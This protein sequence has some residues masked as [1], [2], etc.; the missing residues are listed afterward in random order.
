MIKSKKIILPFLFLAWTIIFAHSIIP[1]H[2]HHELSVV[3]KNHCH[4]ESHKEHHSHNSQGVLSD[5][6]EYN[7]CDH[8]TSEQACHFN[9]K[10]LTQVS[11]DNVFICAEENSL[12]SNLTCVKTNHYNFY[13]DFISEEFPKTNYLR[14]P[15]SL[16]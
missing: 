3:E 11:I 10:V 16:A 5:V 13:Q 14:G 6:S 12:Y 7:C 2:H 1:H 15:P 8:S 9:V 4:H